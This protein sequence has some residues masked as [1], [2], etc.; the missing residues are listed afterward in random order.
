MHTRRL[1]LLVPLFGLF[2]ATASMAQMTDELTVDRPM[3]R[4]SIEASHKATIAP[5]SRLDP[6]Q[7]SAAAAV[8]Y[9]TI[10]SLANCFSFYTLSQEPLRYDPAT[11]ALIMIKRGA[12][13]KSNDVFIRTSVDNGATW[14]EPLGPLHDNASLGGGRYPCVV[15]L[16]LQGSSNPED[17]YYYYCF[18]TVAGGAFGNY[19]WGIVDAN[20]VVI[21]PA[22]NDAGIAPEIWETSALS[23]LSKDNDVLITAG[24]M[25]NNNIGM[26]RLDVTSVTA[27]TSIP[28]QWDA[29]HFSV[30]EG[31][32]RT[33]TVT[34]I[35]RDASNNFYLG[36]YS[37]FPSQ[38]VARRLH[39]WPAYS[40][41]TDKGMTWSDFDI[42]P[43]S[44]LVDYV[45]ANGA[46]ANADSVLFPYW[47]EDFTVT[48][49]GGN[50]VLHW[51]VSCVE[52]DAAKDS[53]LDQFQ[54]VV[55]VQHGPGGW[56]IRKIADLRGYFN[57]VISGDSSANQ[58]D[59]EVMLS[60]T[61]DG[62]KLVCKWLDAISYIFSDDINGDSQSPDTMTT[63]DVFM[64]VRTAAGGSWGPKVNVTETPMFDKC[65]WMPDVTPNDLSAIP[66]LAVQT[67]YDPAS[68]PTLLDSIFYQQRITDLASYVVTFNA[69]ASPSADVKSGDAAVR[70]GMHLSAPTPNPVRDRALV[71]YT[72]P[73][74]GHVVID[75]FN[76]KGERV[77]TIRDQQQEAGNWGFVLRTSELTSG[78]YYYTLRLDGIGLTKMFTVVK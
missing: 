8:S 42:L 33:S 67:A 14:T 5:G 34:G 10:D 56:S 57:H 17:L 73:T 31:S 72:T 53:T 77:A 52:S 22:M 43:I 26:R 23:V 36:A 39:P 58:V 21:A 37:R 35:G 28:S 16:N 38:E 30:P 71:T 7:F 11:G 24:T 13:G 2:W 54:H 18:P 75:L 55:E 9:R 25:S 69:D 32:G 4:P 50:G 41:S 59:N 44:T 46:G 70:A 15:P 48:S 64:S 12:P 47:A 62:S 61:A 40:M 51:A 6:V 76:V 66:M 65:T 27:T 45:N 1:S 60:Q 29:T 20:G 74:A 3:N 63:V 78:T 68:G 49:Q 19:V